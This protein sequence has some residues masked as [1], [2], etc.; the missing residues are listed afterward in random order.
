MLKTATILAALALAGC[1]TEGKA[2]EAAAKARG[3]AFYDKAVD[4]ALFVLCDAASSGSI[5]RQF[6]TSAEGAALYKDLC[7]FTNGS[8]HDVIGPVAREGDG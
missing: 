3:A 1:T 8:N 7:L 6:G 2:F 5:K 4:E